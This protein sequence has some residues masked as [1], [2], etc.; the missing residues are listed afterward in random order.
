[1]LGVSQKAGG[2]RS[3]VGSR[4]EG[5]HGTSC[6]PANIVQR[7]GLRDARHSERSGRS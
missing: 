6:H 4:T 5:T 1:M 2:P 3:E 7:L